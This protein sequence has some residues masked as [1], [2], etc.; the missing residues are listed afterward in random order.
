LARRLEDTSMD[1]AFAS[2]RHY[3]TL[4]F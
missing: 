3:D 4:V 2:R 1:A